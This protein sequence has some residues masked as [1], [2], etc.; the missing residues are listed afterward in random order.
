MISINN[1]FPSHTKSS[2]TTMPEETRSNSEMLLIRHV[3]DHHETQPQP[4][5]GAF[6]Y[7][8]VLANFSMQGQKDQ[9]PLVLTKKDEQSC[10][11]PDFSPSTIAALSSPKRN[12]TMEKLRKAPCA[13]KRFKSAFIFYSTW[14]HKE[15]KK[16]L[17]QQGIKRKVRRC[18]LPA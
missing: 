9:E 8:R 10:I 6:P 18:I 5:N 3:Y 16:E 4:T 17:K 2:N 11:D 7:R 1:R 13:P 15:I 14:K 12:T